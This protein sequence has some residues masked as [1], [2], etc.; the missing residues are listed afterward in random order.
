MKKPAALLMLSSLFGC[1]AY[2]YQAPKPDES[3]A[4]LNID[5]EASLT[6][7]TNWWVNEQPCQKKVEAGGLV[8]TTSNITGRHK[9]VAIRAGQ[10]V[11]LVVVTNATTGITP[12]GSGGTIVNIGN[13][14]AAIRF[15]PENGKVYDSKLAPN[16]CG[17]TLREHQSARLPA[18]AKVLTRTELE[19]AGQACKS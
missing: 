5:G 1:V 7:A 6:A 16:Q 15:T 2:Q 10:P 14:T 17:F 13:C 4:T 18:G 19:Q 12:S 11:Y 9:Q 3:Q 8:S